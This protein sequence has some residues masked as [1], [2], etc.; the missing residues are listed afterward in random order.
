[1]GT[2]S[3]EW[4]SNPDGTPGEVWTDALKARFWANVLLRGPSEC[5]MWTAARFAGGLGY[6]QFRAGKRKVRAHRAAYELTHGPIP[7]GICVCH[8]CDNPACVNPSHL[9]LGTSAENTADR[10]RKGRSARI[11]RSLPRESNPAAKL[12][13]A[14]VR[15]IREAYQRGIRRS[16]LSE[17]YGVSKSQIRHIVTGRSWREPDVEVLAGGP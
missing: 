14:K 5:W 13:M 7:D 12:T 11:G 2:T 10:T 4:T 1:M 9:F 6:G 3:I 16:V 8:A 17:R 15:E